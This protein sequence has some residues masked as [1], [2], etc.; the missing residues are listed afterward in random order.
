M[1]YVPVSHLIQERAYWSLEW[2]RSPLVIDERD[3]FKKARR[4]EPTHGTRHRIAIRD[5]GCLSAG[6]LRT[7]R[8][9]WGNYRM[10]SCVC[11]MPV[12][13]EG[14]H[15]ETLEQA[16]MSSPQKRYSNNYS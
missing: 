3:G 16:C 14:A 4:G 6:H 10:C 1:R 13:G 5:T 11:T 9:D 12:P 2:D 7:G 15:E 8:A